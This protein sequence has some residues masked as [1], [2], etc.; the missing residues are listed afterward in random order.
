MSATAVE[1]FGFAIIP[2]WDSSSSPLISGITKGTSLSIRNAELLS[3]TTQSFFRAISA[4]S[5]VLLE[6][7]LNMAMSKFLKDSGVVSWTTSRFPQ[8]WISR[9]AEREDA[10]NRASVTG[11]SLFSSKLIISWPT[12]PVAP[13]MPILYFFNGF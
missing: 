9:P 2:L 3:I 13:T 1:Q 6:P 7:A 5:W 4:N 10:S 12:A 8:A 11:N